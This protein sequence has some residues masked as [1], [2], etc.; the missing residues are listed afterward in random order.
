MASA[1][2]YS[3]QVALTLVVN[4]QQLA[5]SHVGNSGLRIDEPCD[6]IPATQA[7]LVVSIDD[8]TEERSIY[9]PDGVPGPGEFVQFF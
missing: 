8:K 3:T 4:G 5:V 2:G 9:L 1:S 7:T 6:P